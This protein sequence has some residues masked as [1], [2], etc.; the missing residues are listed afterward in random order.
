M[1]IILLVNLVDGLLRQKCFSS[2]FCFP[3]HKYNSKIFEYGIRNK[4]IRLD[5][6]KSL[7]EH[8]FLRF[9]YI[10][11]FFR[12]DPKHWNPFKFCKLY[13]FSS[14]NISLNKIEIENQENQNSKKLTNF[15]KFSDSLF[16]KHDMMMMMMMM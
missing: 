10:L 3:K 6:H 4:A 8:Y 15:F 11:L 12:Y 13:V 1:R 14:N 7:K 2:R 5:P 16:G 9:E